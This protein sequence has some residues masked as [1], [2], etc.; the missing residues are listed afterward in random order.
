MAIFSRGG[1]M[2]FHRGSLIRLH[3]EAPKH[4]ADLEVHILP[5]FGDPRKLMDYNRGSKLAGTVD[6]P[7]TRP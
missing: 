7:Y 1:H 5:D 3:R 6:T 4:V 2:V